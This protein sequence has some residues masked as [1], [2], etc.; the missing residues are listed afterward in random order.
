MTP[1][2]YDNLPQDSDRFNKVMRINKEVLRS[3]DQTEQDMTTNSRPNGND[4][5]STKKKKKK[6]SLIE[7]EL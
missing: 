6:P 7:D 1:L 4:S 2:D 5:K 3:L